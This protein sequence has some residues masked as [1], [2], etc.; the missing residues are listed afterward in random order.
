MGLRD[1]VR[2]GK[3]P[4]PA[5]AKDVTLQEG[6]GVAPTAPKPTGAQTEGHA[7][8]SSGAN[9]VDTESRGFHDTE[10]AS[11]D[12][13]SATESLAWDN[14]W[15]EAYETIKDDPEYTK[16]LTAFEK[17]VLDSKDVVV[18]A[19]NKTLPESSG[20]TSGSEKLKQIQELAE[21]KLQKIPEARVSFSIGDKEIVVREVVRKTISVV[22]AFKDIIGSAI[23]AEPCAGLAWAGI[24]SILPLVENSLQ[25]DD[26]AETGLKNI[27]F[28]LIRYQRLQDDVLATE[29]QRPGL[30]NSA[31]LVFSAIR[32]KL[33]N[34]YSQIYVYEIR[35][36]LQYA[37]GRAHRASRN[38]VAADDWNSIWADIKS[39]SQM[40]D[41]GV[42]EHIGARTVEAVND[43]IARA[44]NIENLQQATLKSVKAGNQTQLILSLPCAVNAIFDSSEVIG[45]EAPCLRGTRRDVLNRI[46]DWVESP[47]GEVIFWLHGMAGTGKTSVALTVATALNTGRPFTEGRQ[48][49][50]SVFLGAS[51]FFKQGDTTRNGTK[52][53]FPTLARRL[54]QGFPDIGVQI[55]YAVEK[56]LEI[57]TKAPQQQLDGLIFKPLSVIDTE[58]F[59]PVR[60]VIV[61]DALDECI[62][63][64]EVDDLV[65][66]LRALED[67]HQVQLRVLITSR[68]DDHILR[69]FEKLPIEMYSPS[70]LDKVRSPAKEDNEVDDITKYLIH[71]L[72]K[73][74]SE[75]DVP[76]SWIS[77]DSI[78]SLSKKADG[79]FIY[80]ATMC[81]FLD[82]EDFDDMEAREDRLEQILGDEID[83]DAPQQKVDEIYLKVLSFPHLCKLSQ[84]S[85]MK[86]HEKTK[87]ILGFIT[88]FFEPVSVLSLSA[89]LSVDKEDLNK[90]LRKFHSILDVPQDEHAPLGLVHLSFRDFLLNK[91]RSSKLPFR[92]EEIS[93][94]QSVFEAC[95][96]VM[97]QE[98]QQDMCNLV[99]PGH[100][101]SDVTQSQLE[102]GIPRYLRY[103]C[104]YWVDHLA[105]LSDDPR[106]EAGLADG[107]V[108]HLFL[109]E[110]LLFW[111]EAMSLIREMSAAILI[112]NKLSTIVDSI[113]NPILSGLVYDAGRFVLS[114]KLVIEEAPLQIYSSALMFSPSKSKVR[115][116]FRHLIPSWIT[117]VPEYKE[118]WTSELYVLQGGLYGSITSVCFSPLN[119]LL[120]SG[121]I[122]GQTIIWN[123]VTGTKLYE[124]RDS[125]HITCVAFSPDGKTVAS[126]FRDGAI[127]IREFAK[128]RSINLIGHTDIVCSIA[129][130][131]K[132]SNTLASIS[133]DRTLRIWNIEKDQAAHILDISLQYAPVNTTP[134]HAECPPRDVAFSP[135]GDFVAVG[136]NRN[137]RGSVTLWGVEKGELR[138]MFEG[139]QSFVPAIAISPD[140][141]TIISGSNSLTIIVWNAETGQI[142]RETQYTKHIQAILF[143]PPHGEQV[144]IGFFDGTIEILDVNTWCLVESFDINGD[145]SDLS[146]SPDGRFLAKACLGST[147]QLH[148]LSR[149]SSAVPHKD[150]TFSVSFIPSKDDDVITTTRHLVQLWGA[151]NALIKSIPGALLRMWISP[152][153][154]F[155]G[156]RTSSSIVEIW[157]RGMTRKIASYDETY[158][159]I[160]S[161]TSSHVVLQSLHQAR[162][163]DLTTLKEVVALDCN[164]SDI[165][166]FSLDSRVVAWVG[167]P[168]RVHFLDLAASKET[169]GPLS[170]SVSSITFSPDS[171]LLVLSRIADCGHEIL[172]LDVATGNERATISA[173]YWELATFHPAGHLAAVGGV[174]I[175]V[176][177]TASG[178]KIRTFNLDT[179]L[180][181]IVDALAFSTAGDLITVAGRPK[182]G[183]SAIQLWD[184]ATGTMISI[185]RVDTMIQHL[186]FSSDS[187]C[188]ETEHGRVQLPPL[189]NGKAVA[190]DISSKMVEGLFYV[191]GQKAVTGPRVVADPGVVQG[192]DKLLW[193][194]QEL[195][196]SPMS[197]TRGGSLA[198]GLP[199]GTVAYLKFD[200][201]KTP[202]S[203]RN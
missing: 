85:Q 39:T 187:R 120:V 119:D 131:P 183:H 184:F 128:G 167:E 142:R 97:S 26:D 123:Y 157:S 113:E 96:R 60:L 126:G 64:K 94:H 59:I 73:I 2:R 71:T 33:V 152:D 169:V 86:F 65:G 25:Q 105:T 91:E 67:L 181:G 48:P 34:L 155:L 83:A 146:L 90:T 162:I 23:S 143:R 37:R 29:F 112:L 36:V 75:R 42:Q 180:P 16:L 1:L 202:L 79:L 149:A 101:A 76:A 198:F 118:N 156:L 172:L 147:I 63:Q 6:S 165:F 110:K 95:L 20:I 188:L 191:G 18:D 115:S 111:L 129:F 203:S 46:Q 137:S 144:I 69:S 133:G 199:G 160:F 62:D 72:A 45:K 153:K 89:L 173:G 47:T 197:S 78:A 10:S 61:V 28:L 82:C 114:S 124:F 186:S 27:V 134:L 138:T 121:S 8:L 159:M 175:S 196:E 150:K 168:E 19:A 56:N 195:R 103:A 148:D 179:F 38:A 87:R 49:P 171:E 11:K 44:E 77:G 31:Y 170:N 15:A 201:D 135:R 13:D 104:Y 116:M 35:F 40:I 84:K 174:D 127:K 139:H 4:L 58:T 88:A 32:T 109:G 130:S 117:Q 192:F 151:N 24:M 108:V 51:F 68:R 185:L 43:I 21:K 161:P 154:N 193:L 53:F 92:V 136:S 41:Q 106:M 132:T 194:P 17:Y 189:I 102:K 93:M 74:A 30:S 164:F 5:A 182:D 190:L 55:A 98:L 166:A 9:P 14:L 52:T 50:R 57:G 176:W 54:A 140:N 122:A 200:L 163:V 22:T 177:N 66:M 145:Y 99:L 107:K 7:G 158:D 80:A 81:R 70:V 12:A 178:D 141:E 3:R 125:N 100:L